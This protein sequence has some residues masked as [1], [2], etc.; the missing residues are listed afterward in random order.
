MRVRARFEYQRISRQSKRVVGKFILIDYRSNYK[1][2]S[3]LGITVT[4]KY[5][6][7]HDRNRF[8]RLVRE[9]FRLAYPK[10][11]AGLDLNVRPR[12]FAR[13]AHMQDVFTELLQLC[14][15]D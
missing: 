2:L 9:A 5:G 15:Q 7:A 12:N 6:K 14:S 4:K 10:L 13:T 1:T 3:R 8:K 11:P